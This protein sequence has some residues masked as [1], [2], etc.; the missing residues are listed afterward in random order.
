[1]TLAAATL[2]SPASATM[3]PVDTGRRFSVL[4]SPIGAVTLV[5]EGDG[6]RAVLPPGDT[7]APRA[8]RDTP[9]RHD[10]DA[11]LSEAR[12]QLAAWFAGERTAFDLALAPRGTPFQLSVWRALGTI[13]YGETITY[14]ELAR[15]ADR[16]GANRAAGAANGANP[17][18]IVLPCHRV[19]GSD[20]SLTGYSAG[21]EAKRWLIA[22]EQRVRA[23]Q[24][25][26]A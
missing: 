22:H 24:R 9:T 1:M 13:P 20:G 6:L 17:L 5:A 25:L 14:A 11:L 19:V 10:D 12:D 21:L 7:L 16:P 18:S 15:R 26:Q 23:A 8:L 4:E 2:G 3:A